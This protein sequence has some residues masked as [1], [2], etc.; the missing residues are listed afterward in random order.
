VYASYHINNKSN[1]QIN[2][3]NQQYPKAM[4]QRLGFLK[5]SIKNMRETGSVAPS[6]RFLCRGIA[7]KIDPSKAN[8]VVELGP[9]DG[10]ITRYI[11]E[12]LPEDGHLF[13]F[14]INDVF[15][16]KLKAEFDNDPRITVIHDSAELMGAHF[17]KRGIDKVDYII[18]GIPFLMLPDGLAENIIEECRRWLRMGGLFVQFHYAPMM[19]NFYRRK[20]GNAKVDII[21]LNIPPAM[22][23]SCEQ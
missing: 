6:S 22:I 9:G 18:S 16:A 2:N 23:I 7:E 20:F 8:V 10:V 14:E 1:Q 11:L 3:K 19:L 21:P 15:V 17:Q 5:E 4:R 13:I 12:R